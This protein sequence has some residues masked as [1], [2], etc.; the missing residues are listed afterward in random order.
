MKK[1]L[2]LLKRV[3]FSFAALYSFNILL[4][5]F[6]LNIAVNAISLGIVSVLGVPGMI[7]LAIIKAIIK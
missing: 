3:T 4:A 1:I 2:K 5:S 7:S 6:N